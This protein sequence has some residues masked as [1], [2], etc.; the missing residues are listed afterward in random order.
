MSAYAFGQAGLL[1]IQADLR[2]GLAEHACRPPRRTPASHRPAED[3]ALRVGPEP[4][5][6]WGCVCSRRPSGRYRTLSVAGSMRCMFCMSMVNIMSW[7]G[8][9]T[10]FGADRAQMSSPSIFMKTMVSIPIGSSTPT[11]QAKSC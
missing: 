7:P 3:D 5:A 2:H 11:L 6:P 1:W 4:Q 9:L 8:S 10:A